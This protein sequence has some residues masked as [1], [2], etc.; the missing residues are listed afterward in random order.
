[1]R[2][3][4]ILSADFVYLWTFSVLMNVQSEPRTPGISDNHKMPQCQSNVQNW[5]QQNTDDSE[6]PKACLKKS[7]EPSI[8]H[9]SAIV[10]YDESKV[11]PLYQNKR[12]FNFADQKVKIKQNWAGMGIAAV[13]W[14]AVCTIIL[15]Q[16]HC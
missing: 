10:V 3:T 2:T 13:V 7:N 9:S 15:Q 11:L 4:S 1:M 16:N 5:Q 14:E 6:D 8:G 12:E